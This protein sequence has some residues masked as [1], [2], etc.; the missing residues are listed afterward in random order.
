M[1]L[2]LGAIVKRLAV[3]CSSLIVALLLVMWGT[4]MLFK[5][6]INEK[7]RFVIKETIKGD[8][9]FDDINLSFYKKFP[10]L[11]A[12]ISNPSIEGAFSESVVVGELFEAESV[13]LGINVFALIT[14]KVS[15]DRIYIDKPFINVS[16]T[17]NGLSNYDIFYSSSDTIEEED[18]ALELKIARLYIKE[19]EVIYNDYASKLSFV[20]QKFDYVGRGNMSDAIFDLKSVIRIQSFD[21]NFD[22]VHYIKEKPILAKLS[23]QVDTK[24]LTL[25]FERNDIRIKDL[26]VDFKGKFAF[27]DNGYDMLFDIRTVNSSLE[28]LLSVVPPEYQEWL[29]N[30][31][32]KGSVSGDFLLDGKYVVVDSLA[33]DI[34]LNLKVKNG[35]FRH[36]KLSKPLENLGLGFSFELPNLDMQANTISIDSLNF[37]VDGK[38]SRIDFSSRGLDSL[39]T[40]G[41]VNAELNLELFSK[42]VGLSGFDMRGDLVLNGQWDGVYSKDVIVTRTIRKTT[43]DTI[44]S[45]IPVFNVKGV[46]KQGFFKFAQLPEG[47]SHVEVDFDVNNATSE[48]KDTRMN[49]S[50]LNLMAMDNQIEGKVL[51]KN[52]RNYDLDG[53]IKA[54]IDLSTLKEFLPVTD[55]EIRG[56]AQLDGQ[57]S[58]SFEPSR[59]RFPIIDADFKMKDG[60]LRFDQMPELPVE[61]INVH[62]IVTSKRGSLY[63]LS[64]K[65]MPIDFRIANEPFQLA[66]SLYNLD[67]LRYN[68]RSKGVLNIDNIYKLFKLDGLDVKGKVRTN[69]FL[70]GLQSDAV[71]GHFDKLRNGGRFEVDNI[72]VSSELFPKPLHIKK[73][74]FKFSEEKMEFNKFLARYGSSEFNMNG[75]LT[76]VIDY[77]LKDDVLQGQFDLNTPYMNIDEF[78]VYADNNTGSNVS[79]NSGVIQVPKNVNIVF[80]ANGDKVKYTDYAINDFEGELSIHNGQIDLAK[81]KFDMIGTNVEMQGSYRPHNLRKASFDYSIQAFNFDIQRAYKEV[82]MFREMVSMAKDTYGVVSLDYKLKGNLNSGMFPIMPSLVGDGVLTLEDVSFK[83]FKLLGAIADKTDAKSIEKSNVN[84][85]DILS[86]VKDNVL[87]IERTKMKMAGFRPRFEGQ[88][89]LDG[90][91]NIGLRLGL[92]PLGIIGIPMKITGN[93]DN[94]DIKLGR[95]KPSEVL[96]RSSENDDEEEGPNINSINDPIPEIPSENVETNQEIESSI[97]EAA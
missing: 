94:F 59:K 62:T 25:I 56:I 91:M 87:T 60:Y 9:A 28:Q 67:N 46:L 58:G 18:K 88:V 33:P 1:S 10:Y 93:S 82:P 11:T 14:G 44:I 4:P 23:T 68:V 61:D 30:T 77:L 12:T 51:L 80:R 34:S 72:F 89:S 21:L 42:A 79:K 50:H 85:V 73:G 55:L 48:Y 27:I 2:K 84:Q 52:M 70:S 5:D 71:N 65:V 17:E 63:D 40:K 96:G 36:G 13:S 24:S 22:G 47:L 43:N 69:L 20:M 92:P 57:V 26:P 39:V 45:S 31:E 86:S 19:A 35:F 41:S 29:A 38:Q 74:V 54:N 7:V 97:I 49:I 6:T 53:N 3:I 16:V 15:F 83:S 37:F 95:Y 8:V 90:E 81:A 64:I 32:I 75:Y 66:A 76:N 78:M